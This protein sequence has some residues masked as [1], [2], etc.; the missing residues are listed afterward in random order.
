MGEYQCASLVVATGGPSI[1]TLGA[2]AWGYELAQQFGLNVIAPRAA[3]VPFIITDH[4]KAL[5]SELSGTALPVCVTVGNQSFCDDMLFT[6]RGLSGPA[7]LQISSYWQEGES[8]SVDLIPGLEVAQAL[9]K[10][11]H[12]RPKLLLKNYLAELTTQKFAEHWLKNTPYLEKNLAAL[13]G[14]DMDALGDALNAWPIKPAGTEGYRTAEVALGG[15]DTHELSSKT[16][17]SL[18]HPGLFFI[19][20]V[21]DV[22]GWLG[23]YNFQWAWSSAVACAEVV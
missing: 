13:N 15:V 2:S 19:G 11:Q 21:V 4:Y 18:K 16:L 3:L 22:T 10:E 20:E 5:C 1:P 7:M 8:L 17:E 12:V 14:K 23:G 9:R 6:H